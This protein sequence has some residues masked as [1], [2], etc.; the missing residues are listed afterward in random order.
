[1]L[2]PDD[3]HP[4]YEIFAKRWIREEEPSAWHIA[5]D[6]WIELWPRV[7]MLAPNGRDGREKHNSLLYELA[8]RFSPRDF[9]IRR[10]TFE[11]IECAKSAD[12]KRIAR[13]YRH[14]DGRYEIQYYWYTP[15]RG[16]GYIQEDYQ[17][18]TFA[19]SLD[20]ARQAA[21]DELKRLA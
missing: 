17:T 3:D 18:Y 19:S 1:M 8:A 4:H 6:G 2:S 12:G 7:P 15:G 16:G 20:E 5:P 11:R 10:S 21:H 13:I 14:A 9:V